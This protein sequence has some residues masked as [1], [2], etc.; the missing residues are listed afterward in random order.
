VLTV[1]EMLY[2]FQ[3]QDIVANLTFR[4]FP[5]FVEILGFYAIALLWVPFF[6]PLWARMPL[7]LRLL[8]PAVLAAA[9]VWLAEHFHFWDLPPLRAIL[10]EHEDYYTWG[11]FT[12]GPLIFL[13]LMIG[14]ALALCNGSSRYRRSLAAGLL[15]VA[16]SL[17]ASFV[18]LSAPDTL[19]E[20]QAIARNIGKHPPQTLF[21]LFSLGGAFLI[22]AFS[23]A[24][25]QTLARWLAPFTIIGSNALQAFIFH[26][27]VIFVGFRYLMGYW[28]SVSYEFALWL[29]LGL[30][31]ATAVWIKLIAW[32]DVNR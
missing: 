11:Q 12:R 18:V 5:S 27:L 31:L 9:G 22:L 8:S 19:G 16:L 2:L 24:G 3:P 25:G 17:F 10:V 6:L 1:A 15:L 23:V 13:G 20:I 7:F 30:I 21:M 26:I 32:I 29:T 28:H 14:E 4:G